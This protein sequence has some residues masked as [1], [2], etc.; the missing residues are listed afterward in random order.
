MRIIL[1]ATLAAALLA[2]APARG[3]ELCAWMKE[4][5]DEESYR[6]VELW[7]EANQRISF[8]YTMKGQGFREIGEDREARGYSPGAGT[9]VLDGGVPE[10]PWGF[11]MT[12]Y[13]P[14]EI[15]I[16]AEIREWPKDVF[17]DEEPPLITAFTFRRTIPEDEEAPPSTFAEK[18]C[19]K[20]D[21]PDNR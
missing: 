12:L 16:V 6:E 3:A 14:G 5:V 17:A 4:T 8:Y 7:L 2:G 10:K 18:Q 19:R 15:D 1:T 13:P 11:G 21:F 20:A 9:Y